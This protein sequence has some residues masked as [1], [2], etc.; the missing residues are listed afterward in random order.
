MFKRAL[1]GNESKLVNEIEV[2]GTGLWTQLLSRKVLTKEQIAI[3]QNQVWQ[4]LL[5]LLLVYMMHSCCRDRLLQLTVSTVALHKQTCN[6]SHIDD[7]HVSQCL[8]LIKPY[9]GLNLPSTGSR[10]PVLLAQEAFCSQ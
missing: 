6:C 10:R 7:S 9:V 8:H 5:I 2:E 1:E 3:C 4:S